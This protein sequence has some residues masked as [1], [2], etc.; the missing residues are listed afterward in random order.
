MGWL[1]A[2]VFATV[3]FGNFAIVYR[4]YLRKQRGSLVPVIGGLAGAAACFLLP[5]SGLCDWWLL[6][7]VIDPG[8]APLMLYTAAFM[9]VQLFKRRADRE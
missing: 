3:T 4:W 6:P 7:L 1:L 8:S 2:A 5:M 9:T